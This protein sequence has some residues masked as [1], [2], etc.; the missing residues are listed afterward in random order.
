MADYFFVVRSFN[1]ESTG[2]NLENKLETIVDGLKQLE[3]KYSGVT[4]CVGMGTDGLIGIVKDADDS[5]WIEIQEHIRKSSVAQELNGFSETQLGHSKNADLNREKEASTLDENT[6]TEGLAKWA[7]VSVDAL[8]KSF[9]YVKKDY[10]LPVNR[11][12]NQYE[13]VNHKE[14]LLGG[15]G[16]MH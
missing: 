7:R 1:P 13:F 9:Q 16:G 3:K 12:D 8:V 10:D 14:I 6:I 2:E 11:D 15:I 5:D 4:I